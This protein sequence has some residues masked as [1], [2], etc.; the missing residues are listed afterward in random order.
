MLLVTSERLS[1]E[2]SRANEAE[3]QS[4]EILAHFKIAHQAKQKLEIDLQ[5]VKDEL[6]LYKTQLDIAQAGTFHPQDLIHAYIYFLTWVEIRRAQE[7]VDKV[8]QQRAD[9]EDEARR[10]REK[11]RKL[12]EARAVELAM[13][14][15][16]RLGYEEGMRQGRLMMQ[17][18]DSNK[19]QPRRYYRRTSFRSAHEDDDDQVSYF[20]YAQEEQHS[21]ESSR[22]PT[23]RTL[24]SSNQ[25]PSSTSK[26]DNNASRPQSISIQPHLTQD[27][28]PTR[29]TSIRNHSPTISHRSLKLP[30]DGYIPTADA[31][32]FISLPPPH[33]LSR[34][35]PPS[36]ASE[37]STTMTSSD[38]KQER[39]K[40]SSSRSQESR[41]PTSKSVDGDSASHFTLSGQ[42]HTDKRNNRPTHTRPKSEASSTHVSESS[43]L[44]TPDDTGRNKDNEEEDYFSQRTTDSRIQSQPQAS[45]QPERIAAKWRYVNPDTMPSPSPP[46]APSAFL[47]RYNESTSRMQGNFVIEV[48]GFFPF[49][50]AAP[51]RSLFRS[52]N[53]LVPSKDSQLHLSSSVQEVRIQ[54]K[55]HNHAPPD[56]HEKSFYQLTP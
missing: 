37:P 43:L 5:R 29:P 1:Q 12:T 35:V 44:G 56:V 20:S 23:I 24:S 32:S 46:P 36:G 15:G 19:N 22:S 10:G 26:P 14:E 27:S 7:I 38:A 25:V 47:D 30:P 9:A 13:E 55:D 6:G 40:T 4:S 11:V 2:T 41:Q 53:F 33:E 3:R 17:A 31:N 18:R 21:T 28:N 54:F 34:P 16:R 52:S 48:S 45:T 39:K 50:S 42:R 8:D 49:L 51:L